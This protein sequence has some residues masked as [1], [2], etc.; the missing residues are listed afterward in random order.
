[1][2]HDRVYILIDRGLWGSERMV[3]AYLT[4]K[5]LRAAIDIRRLDL[6]VDIGD[7]LLVQTWAGGNLLCSRKG[8]ELIDD[9]A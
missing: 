4:E 8:S 9:T 5:A 1:M 7:T 2:T 3:G 6:T